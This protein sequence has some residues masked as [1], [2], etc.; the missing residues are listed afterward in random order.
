MNIKF[1]LVEEGVDQ[2]AALDLLVYRLASNTFRG[3][4][5]SMFPLDRE[6][7]SDFLRIQELIIAIGYFP[8]SVASLAS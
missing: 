3:V 4:I 2:F 7:F 6:F 8:N 5:L 1:G